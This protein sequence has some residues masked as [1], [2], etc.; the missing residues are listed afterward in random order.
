MK[1]K[2]VNMNVQVNWEELRMVMNGRVDLK[3]IRVN[4]NVIKM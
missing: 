4:I 2:I 1:N 3:L